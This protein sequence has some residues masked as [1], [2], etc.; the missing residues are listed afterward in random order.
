MQTA[1]AKYSVCLSKPGCSVTA[2]HSGK[3]LW[4]RQ[5]PSSASTTTFGGCR[6]AFSEDFKRFM[7]K[8]SIDL[9]VAV[10][11][12]L[13]LCPV[14]LVLSVLV[15]FRLGG[16]VLFRQQ[17]P[18]LQGKPFKMLKFRTMTDARGRDG[19]LLPDA[20]RLTPFGQWLRA[21]SLDELP[22]LWNVLLGAHVAAQLA[23]AGD[24]TNLGVK[25]IVNGIVQSG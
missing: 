19:A 9:L 22:E 18:G 21:S 20:Q 14:M 12:L 4:P 23:A 5:L 13:L 2:T 10:V 3:S 24:I 11:G 16:P 17:R 7:F 6:S 15:R 25:S 1:T 8:R